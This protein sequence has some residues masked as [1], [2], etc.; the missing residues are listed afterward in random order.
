MIRPYLRHIGW[1]HALLADGLMAMR[2]DPL[3]LPPLRASRNDAARHLVLARTE[4]IWVTATVVDRSKARGDGVHF[5]GRVSLCRPLAHDLRGTM[6][7][8]ENGRAIAVGERR[9]RVGDL[10]ELDERC[11]ALRLMPEADAALLLRA[12]VAPDG[13]VRSHVADLSSGT[14]VASAQADERHARTLM[15]LSLLRLTGWRDAARHFVDALDAPLP[16]QRWAVMREYL[17]LDTA[18]ALPCLADMARTEPDAAVRALARR[19]FE[20][21]GPCR[22]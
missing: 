1:F 6:Y 3:H 10:L 5:S 8:L 19:T 20:G 16:G 22:A 13:P 15:L 21:I 4:R 7:R 2:A 14:V 12:Q 11:E 18:A 9:V 17:A